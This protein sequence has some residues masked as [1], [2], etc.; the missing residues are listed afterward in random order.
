MVAKAQIMPTHTDD[1]PLSNRHSTQW[2]EEE[3]QRSSSVSVNT[4]APVFNKYKAMN[5]GCVGFV[6]QT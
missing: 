3:G 6:N 4:R 5:E 2:K 1:G